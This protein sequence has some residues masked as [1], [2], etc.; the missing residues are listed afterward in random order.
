MP[1]QKYKEY[2]AK[3]DNN[4]KVKLCQP[5]LNVAERYYDCYY[6]DFNSVGY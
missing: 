1:F 2:Q 4:I 6:F 3:T 5:K